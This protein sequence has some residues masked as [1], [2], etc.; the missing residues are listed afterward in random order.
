MPEPDFFDRLL[1]R[2]TGLGDAVTARP[3]LP[4]PFE[5]AEPRWEEVEAPPEPLRSASEPGARPAPAAPAR[6]ERRTEIRHTE[7]F[8]PRVADPE[9]DTPIPS[10][11][12][13]LP[14]EPAA[15]P[16]RDRVIVS[17]VTSEP[18]VRSAAVPPRSP[19]P[20]TA[21]AEHPAAGPAP[22]PRAAAREAPAA[23]TR[24]E[25]ARPPVSHR[26]A[27]PAEPTVRVTIGRLEVRATAPERTP[28]RTPRHGRPTP[29]VNLS[30]YL[31][32]EAR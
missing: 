11:E 2:H 31:S 10:T 29:V 9:P 26:R 12:P 19:A 8:T 17:R 30:D 23:P 6:I 21:R 24:P 22:L 20:T 14:A 7:R 16:P 25:S 5:R 1:A 4:G 18:P 32:G 27:R 15:R 28:A 13:T 3:R